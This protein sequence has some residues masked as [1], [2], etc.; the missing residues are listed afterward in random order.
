VVTDNSFM[1]YA[2]TTNQDVGLPDEASTVVSGWCK[3]CGDDIDLDESGWV[4]HYATG[5]YLK[6]GDS[7]H[8]SSNRSGL[9]HLH[10]RD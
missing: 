4:A 1:E 2:P 8:C 10:Q 9:H 6:A 3:H 5:V 7:G